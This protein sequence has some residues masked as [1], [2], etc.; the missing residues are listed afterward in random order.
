MESYFFNRNTLSWEKKIVLIPVGQYQDVYSKRS[1]IKFSVSEGCVGKS[2]AL[3]SFVRVD[4]KSNG[5]REKYCL[6]CASKLSI[7]VKKAK[8]IIDSP[9]VFLGFPVR[10][11]GES[12]VFGVISVEITGKKVSFDENDARHI[13]EIVSNFSPFFQK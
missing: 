2:Y 12:E 5:D 9:N 10:F 6:E 7:P 1:K 3:R 13:E 11:F 8:K 4:V